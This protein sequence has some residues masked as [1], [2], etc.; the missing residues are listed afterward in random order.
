MTRSSAKH[1][2]QG[3]MTPDELREAGERLYGTWGWQ[4]KLAHELQVD[5]STVRRW[6]SG[7]VPIPGMAAVAIG[8]LIKLHSSEAGYRGKT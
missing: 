8:L 7:K 6:L 4:T 3:G 5:G 2:S 1:G